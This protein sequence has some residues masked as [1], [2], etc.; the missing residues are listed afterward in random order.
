MA[1]GVIKQ[2]EGHITAYS[3]P[4]GG[5]TFKIYLPWYQGLPATPRPVREEAALPRGSET[6][7]L[8]EDEQALRVMA[9]EILQS[10][11]YTV[12]TAADG[13]EAIE[14]AKSYSGRIH[15]LLSDVVMPNGG[16][17]VVADQVS[18]LQPGI[19]VLFASGYTDDAVVR[20]GIV[21]AEMAFLQKPYSPFRLASKVREVL[22]RA[23]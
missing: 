16:G 21:E 15:L 2:S 1:Y 20:H 22:D 3:E 7:L 8:A 19:R 18:T 17:R 5:T 12:L 10:C 6:I 11:G 13:R 9:E 4:G 23:G 14:V